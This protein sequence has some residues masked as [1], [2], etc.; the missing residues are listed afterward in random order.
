MDLNAWLAQ[1][2]EQPIDPEM[3]II[4]PHHHLW[5]Y[6]TS[7]YMVEE[8]LEDIGSGHNVVAT[9]FVECLSM[10]RAD[11]PPEMKPVGETEFVRRVT[12]SHNTPGSAGTRVAA[13][14]VGYADLTLG[15][16]VK[17][18]LEAHI[19]AGGGAFRGIRHAA[20]WVADEGI[21]NAHTHPPRGLLL[22]AAFREGFACLSGCNLSFDAWLYHPQITE[23]A[24][25]A[26]AFPETQIILDHVGGIL[27]MGSFAGQR[28]AVFDQWKRDVAELAACENVAIKLGGLGMKVCGFDWHRREKPP[29][30]EALAEAFAPYYHYCIDT[31]GVGRCMFESNFPVD[32]PSSSYGVLWNAFKRMSRHLTDQERAALFH[33][34]AARIY[35]L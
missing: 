30:S 34:N 31:F 35:R 18:V 13:G 12:A 21:N 29:T 27:G 15:A 3:P 10:Y 2:D 20:S 8:L 11:G 23:L 19:A 6:P 32:R 24:D 7:R 26:R 33:D 4:D 16:A 17:P 1:I 22:D 5:D 25:L 28:E 14:I 9:V